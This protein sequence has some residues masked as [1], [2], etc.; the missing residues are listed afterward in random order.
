[1][2]RAPTALD[3]LRRERILHAVDCSVEL[4][5]IALAGGKPEA[6]SECLP[7]RTGGGEVA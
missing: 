2:G 4:V 5:Q 6:R 1:M 7:D 3:G